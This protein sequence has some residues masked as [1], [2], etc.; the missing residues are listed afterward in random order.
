MKN[1]TVT[2][3]DKVYREARVTAAKLGTSVS[4]IVANYL[5][6]IARGTAPVPSASDHDADQRKELVRLFQQSN[7]VLGYKP[8]RRKSYER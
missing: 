1:I 3:D 4:A 8:N 6:A 7:L 2:V 5:T